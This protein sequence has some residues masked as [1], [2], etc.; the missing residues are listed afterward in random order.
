[1]ARVGFRLLLAFLMFTAMWIYVQRVLIPHQGNEGVIRQIP[2][3]N[4]SDLYPRWLGA[5][6]LLLHHRDPY[7]ADITREIQVGYYGRPLDPGRPNDPRDQQAFAYPVYV[8]LL[9]APTVTLPFATVHRLSFWIFLSLTVISIPLWMQTLRW[10]VSK[11][12]L[13]IWVLLT[14]S[15]FPAI[16]ALKLQQL[17]ILVAALVAGSTTA[18]VHRRYVLAGILLAIA[19]I[20]PQLVILV[21]VCALIW[22]FGA[23]RERQRFFWSF[24][25]TSCVLVLAGQFLLPGWITEFRGAMRSYSDYT[26]GGN[27]LLDLLPSPLGQIASV[28]VVAVLLV[29]AWRNRHADQESLA[30]QW[31]L[32]TALA[33]TLLVI[34]FSPYNELL[35]LPA[36]MIALRAG[37]QIWRSSPVSRFLFSIAAVSILWPYIA[38]ACLVLALALLPAW[39]VQNSWELPF[40]ATFAVPVIVYGLLFASKNVLVNSDHKASQ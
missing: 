33:T 31:L 16:Q 21:F 7:R 40:Y 24:A 6:E 37:E 19:T 3:G 39:R 15:C 9:L 8:V 35:L 26:G 27:L 34:R 11:I 23:W 12:S 29:L 5:R 38:A 14:L 4:L 1:L 32:C 20:K 18:L 2:R 13:A 10:R 28:S 22:V 30:F 17:T 36:A 25:I